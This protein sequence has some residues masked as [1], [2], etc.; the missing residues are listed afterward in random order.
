LTA[1]KLAGDRLGEHSRG[2]FEVCGF[3][4]A[5]GDR[6]FVVNH[7]TERGAADEARHLVERVLVTTDK[8]FKDA[9]DLVWYN[10]HLTRDVRASQVS[11]F[12]GVEIPETA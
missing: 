6:V 5:P 9:V 12:V 3:P 7:S 2:R 8:S 4:T 10:H 1:L 11:A